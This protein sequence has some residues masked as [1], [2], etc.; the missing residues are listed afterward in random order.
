MTDAQSLRWLSYAFLSG[1][2]A[3]LVGRWA[4]GRA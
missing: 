3:A 2:V 1:A 4:W